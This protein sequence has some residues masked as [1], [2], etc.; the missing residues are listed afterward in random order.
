MNIVSTSFVSLGIKG[1][2]L[3]Y[4][5]TEYSI[6]QGESKVQRHNINAWGA[7]FLGTSHTNEMNE[8]Y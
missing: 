1:H 8:A 7:L 6:R 3:I 4:K 2:D 5:T